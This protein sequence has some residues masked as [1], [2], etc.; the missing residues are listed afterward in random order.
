[1]YLFVTYLA[2]ILFVLLSILIFMDEYQR[3]Y[4]FERADVPA[5][6]QYV[7]KINYPFKV[8]F[9]CSKSN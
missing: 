8:H 5:G 6:K 7:L 1:M 2:A 4:A 9:S 3:N